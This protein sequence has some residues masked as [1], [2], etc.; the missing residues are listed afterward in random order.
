MTNWKARCSICGNIGSGYGSF[1]RVVASKTRGRRFESS[2]RQILYYLYA[3][4]SIEEDE[5]EKVEM[6]NKCC[7]NRDSTIGTVTYKSPNLS[8]K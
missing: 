6:T 3:D 7:D 5:K 4:N 1:G 2:H 8:L